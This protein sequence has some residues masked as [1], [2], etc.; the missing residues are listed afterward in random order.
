MNRSAGS[1]TIHEM[2]L[3]YSLIAVAHALEAKLEAALAEVGLSAAKL[4]VLTLLAEAGEPL[5]LG[6]L[7]AR[8]QCVRSNMTQL[9]D[10]LEAEGLVRRVPDPID[11]RSVRAAL[12][13]DGEGRQQAGAVKAAALQARFAEAL[14][15][16]DRTTLRRI[17]SELG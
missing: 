7:A 1:E 12:T 11:R 2:P 6:D 14:P 9:V 16:Q 5:T 3:L 4:G 10:R 8:Q 15:E 17:L 13:E